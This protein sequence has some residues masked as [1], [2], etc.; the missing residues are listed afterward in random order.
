MVQL[1]MRRKFELDFALRM[2][3]IVFVQRQEIEYRVTYCSVQL[4]VI[5][6]VYQTVNS[7]DVVKLGQTRS[8]RISIAVTL[9]RPRQIA[10]ARAGPT[11]YSREVLTERLERGERVWLRCA[12]RSS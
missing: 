9:H 4:A 3:T 6:G 7:K 5:S 12:L 11:P 2:A 8:T 1:R 10:A